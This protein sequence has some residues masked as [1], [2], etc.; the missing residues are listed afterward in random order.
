MN[1]K[2]KDDP[3]FE[4]VNRILRFGLPVFFI[5]HAALAVIFF[6]LQI[7]TLFYY[8]IGSVILYFVSMIIC[9]KGHNHLP[10][11]L[12]YIEIFGAI[13]LPT[14][15]LGWEM[16]TYIWIFIQSVTIF[17]AYKWKPWIKISL[18]ILN[19]LELIILIFILRDRDP[20]ILLTSIQ[21]RNLFYFNFFGLL[22]SFFA[23]FFYFNWSAEKTEAALSAEHKKSRKLLLNI[24]PEPI[25]NRLSSGESMIAD[26]YEQCTILFADLVGFTKLSATMRPEDLVN[27]LN[28]I[29]SEFDNIAQKWDLE[30]IKTIGDAYM[31]AAGIPK[32]SK[33]HAIKTVYFAQDILE[34][35]N[36]I[37]KKRG[38]KLQLR[39]G[40]HTGK[41]VA[42]VIGKSKFSY[43][44][45]GDA[46]NTASRMES[47]G[48]AGRIQI[49]ES[50]YKLVKD[51]ITIETRGVQ[52]VKGKGEME[53]YL[54]K[55][56]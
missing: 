33:K 8:N 11:S 52:K 4:R 3:H 15:I 44:I 49:S 31:A 38:T 18:V 34:C 51:E 54:V 32:E 48:V 55:P 36:Q 7:P 16:G 12:A 35:L 21:I 27:M 46:V 53:L 24:L 25:A 9:L 28:E 56:L 40:I 47:H 50:T 17:L 13:I 26:S 30:K 23:T 41:A 43:D 39:V 14:I 22:I 5:F 29:F 20:Q 42:G 45:W 37:N 19:L 1:E 6:F 2:L 10:I